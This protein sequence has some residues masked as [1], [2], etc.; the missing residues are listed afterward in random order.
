MNRHPSRAGRAIVVALAVAMLP[1]VLPTSAAADPISDQK[2]LVAKV[3]DQLE[4]LQAQ[5]DQ[6]AENYAQ[7]MTEKGQLDQ[8]VAAAEQQVKEQQAAVD[9]LRGQLAQVA[10]QA[11]MGAGTGSSSPM[12]NSTAGVTDSLA[13]DQ[14]SR[15]AVGSG[16]ASTDEYDQAVTD[17]KHQQEQL[18]A[19]RDAAQQKAEQIKSDKQAADDQAVEYTKARQDA[20][21]KLGQLVQE[22]EERRARES[23]EK[24]QREAEEAAAKQRAAEQA[25]AAAA[26]AQQQA[27]AAQAQQQAQ[28]NAAPAVRAVAAA[29]PDPEPVNIPATSSRAAGAVQAALSQQGVAYVGYKASPSE[30]FDCSGLTMWAWAQVGVSLPH[31]SKAQYET[32]PHV[33]KD[34]AQPG[35]LLF[36]H[37][38]I[39]HV[40]MYIGNGQQVSAPHTGAVVYV[41]GVNWGQV[42]GVA[43]PG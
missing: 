19:S 35:D 11:Y 42:V 1:A 2:A 17:L 26:Q 30:G 5:S 31:Y 33:P 40:T 16:T 28:S 7:A 10:V 9:A 37:S 12:F 3:T 27:A 36:F 32:L 15:V 4:A 29:T 43:R 22:E 41:G 39:S 8:Q 21:A 34:Q 38:P 18:E 24:M 20:E 13:R 25:A 14:L 6:L 23:Y